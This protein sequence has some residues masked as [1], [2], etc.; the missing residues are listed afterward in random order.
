MGWSDTFDGAFMPTHSISFRH[1]MS[2]IAVLAALIFTGL[3]DPTTIF[4]I[5][6]LGVS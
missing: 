2:H 5:L 6:I 3:F 4:I 1:K